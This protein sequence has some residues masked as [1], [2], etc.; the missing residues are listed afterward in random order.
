MT[1]DALKDSSSELS[2]HRPYVFAVDYFIKLMHS[3]SIVFYKTINSKLS[4]NT[5]YIDKPKLKIT[6]MKNIKN[7]STTLIIV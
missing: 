2:S 3:F 6:N 5:R 4:S 1:T 7:M